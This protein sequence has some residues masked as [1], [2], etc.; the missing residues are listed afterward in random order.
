VHANGGSRTSATRF[1]PDWDAIAESPEFRE[2]ERS[3]RRFLVPAT[4][5]FCTYFVVFLCLLAYAPDTMAKHAIGSVT[6]ALLAGV[7]VVLVGFVMAWLYTRRSAGWA[8]LSERVAASARRPA[9]G[10]AR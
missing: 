4:T 3:R 6:V 1:E 7:S 8:E 9:G 5:F 2:L 10:G